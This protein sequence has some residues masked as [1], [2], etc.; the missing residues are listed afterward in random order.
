MYLSVSGNTQWSVEA[1]VRSCCE[2]GVECP[3]DE[4]VVAVAGSVADQLS[5]CM[6]KVARVWAPA[7]AS[8]VRDGVSPAAPHEWVLDAT[9]SQLRAAGFH[10]GEVDALYQH[11]SEAAERP[12]R[13][14]SV[15]RQVADA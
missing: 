8:R 6:L 3:S 14:A 12:D 15:A 13:R 1:Y 11:V 2:G 5:A 9:E 7:A 10:A 4:A